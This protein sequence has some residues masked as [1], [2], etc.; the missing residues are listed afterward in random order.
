MACS[1]HLRPHTPEKYS[2]R[3]PH[4]TPRTRVSCWQADV[5]CSPLDGS[6]QELALVGALAT[7]LLKLD[8]LL[9]ADGRENILRRR[10]VGGCRPAGAAANTGAPTAARHRTRR[11]VNSHPRTQQTR[12]E[13]RARGSTRRPFYRLTPRGGKAHSASV[14]AH[15]E[16]GRRRGSPRQDQEEND[17]GTEAAAAHRARMDTTTV[18]RGSR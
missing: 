3:T 9:S 6:I 5:Q 10:L 18:P 13:A 16:R 8:P 7:F 4:L 17:R 1:P 12:A 11:R 14:S 15:T 2:A